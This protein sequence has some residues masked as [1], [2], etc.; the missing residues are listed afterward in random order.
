MLDS[1]KQKKIAAMVKHHRW[2]KISKELQKANSEEKVEFAKELGIDLHLS[3]TNYLLTL[4]DDP[5][6]QVKLQAIKSLGN[7]SSDTAKTYL[8][9]FL[10]N[11]PKEKT[12]LEKAARDAI[13]QI[14]AVLAKKDE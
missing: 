13:S 4:L 5:D 1:K 7:H 14:N 3:N 9:E 11:L 2:N 6:D 12:E 8:Q 10:V